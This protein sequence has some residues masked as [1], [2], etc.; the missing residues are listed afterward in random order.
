MHK[1]MFNFTFDNMVE[2]QQVDTRFQEVVLPLKFFAKEFNN[3]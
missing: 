3:K 1:N 2:Q